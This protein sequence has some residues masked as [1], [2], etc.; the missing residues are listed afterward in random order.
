MLQMSSE[1]FPCDDSLG[2]PFLTDRHCLSFP[3]PCVQTPKNGP[4]QYAPLHHPLNRT[5]NRDFLFHKKGRHCSPCVRQKKRDSTLDMRMCR[6]CTH[7]LMWSM[8]ESRG[9][10]DGKRE[11]ERE[12]ERERERERERES[13]L[14]FDELSL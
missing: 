12:S 4:S 6:L 13:V 5:K 14:F 1:T 3:A 7:T 8:R 11:R 9:S 2:T 10:L